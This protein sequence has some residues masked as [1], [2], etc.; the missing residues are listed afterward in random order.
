M[1]LENRNAIVYGGGGAVGGGIARTFAREGARVHLAGRT[2]EPLDRVVDEIR[3]AGGYAEAAVLDVLDEAAVTDHAAG[4]AARGGLDVSVNLVTRGDAQ[5]VPLLEM[6]VADFVRPVTTGLTANFITA[7]AAARHMARQGSGVILALDSGSAH[8]SPMMG[9]TGPADAATDALV[10]NL[11]MEVGPAG[12]RVVGL[13]IAGVPETLSPAK[14]AAVNPNLQVDEAAL[15][16]LLGQL[17]AMRML[18]RSPG[19]AE[20]A[21]TAAFLASDLAAGITGTFVNVTGGLFPS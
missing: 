11:A 5:G 16:G 1:L 18:R 2:R 4:V 17:A 13:W 9:G 3:S 15:E 20:V 21:A 12:V 19:L 8:G 14:L 7:R 10:R 6:S